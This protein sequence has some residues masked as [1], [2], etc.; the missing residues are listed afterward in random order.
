M[1]LDGTCAARS[2][3]KLICDALS[4][5]GIQ[6]AV[7]SQPEA[8]SVRVR[9]VHDMEHGERRPVAQPAHASAELANGPFQLIEPLAHPGHCSTCSRYCSNESDDDDEPICRIP[10]AS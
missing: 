7:A 9:F 2:A 4:P 6:V 10:F 3:A 1:H 5:S 8:R